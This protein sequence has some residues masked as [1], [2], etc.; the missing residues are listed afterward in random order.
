MFSSNASR[1][2]LVLAAAFSTVSSA[3]GIRGTAVVEEPVDL[4]SAGD[5]VILTKSGISSVPTSTITGDI[6]VSPIAATAITGFS[7]TM[8]PSNQFSRSDQVDGKVFA[9]DYAPPTPE[10]LTEAVIDMEE[11]YTDAAGR[12]NADPDRKNIGGGI[13]GGDSAGGQT[14]PL[15]PGVYT[16]TSGVTIADDIFFQGRGGTSDVFIIQITGTLR[17]AVGV[18]VHL[19]GGARAENIFWQVADTVAV[20]ADAHM[21][22]IILAQTQV[23]FETGSYLNGRVLAQTACNLQMATITQPEPDEETLADDVLAADEA[24]GATVTVAVNDP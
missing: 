23:L 1:F 11:A 8:D 15:T 7:L 18:V 19:T 24:P 21:E 5:Y 2:V 14:A 9:A 20:G 12:P 16:F 17:E 6:A 13:L 4:A 10:K 22:G 3:G